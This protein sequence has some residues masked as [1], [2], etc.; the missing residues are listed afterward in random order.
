MQNKILSKHY[1]LDSTI[2]INLAWWD[3]FFFYILSE[4]FIDVFKWR[5]RT[6]EHRTFVSWIFE[7]ITSADNAGSNILATS[8]V[9]VFSLQWKAVLKQSWFIL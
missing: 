7:S 6:A 3:Q 1:I 5:F 8:L 9:F 4:L 2:E